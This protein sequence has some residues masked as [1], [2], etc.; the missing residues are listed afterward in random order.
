MLDRLPKLDR[1]P[2][3]DRLKV[4]ARR[5]LQN[6]VAEVVEDSAQRS[7]QAG[8][9]SHA[10][11]LAEIARLHEH[12]DLLQA[13]LDSEA[14]KTDE[15][16]R[17]QDELEFRERRD[18]W[19]AEDQLVTME[20]AEFVMKHM[21]KTP[22]FWDQYDTLRFALDEVKVPGMA[23]EF[24]VATGTTLRI[25]AESLDDRLVAGFDVFTGLPE[26]WR[27][28]FPAGQFA[29]DPPEVP[30]ATIVIGM[31]ED[32]LPGFLAEHDEQIA[33]LHVDADL[34]SSAKTVLDLVT[35]RL[36]PGAVLLFDE[37]FNYPNWQQHEYRAF[38]EFIARTGRTFTY[39]GYTGNNEQVA[40][41]LD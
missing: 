40:V 38:T 14:A 25:I 7:Q 30:G 15:I 41:R 8:E 29:Q 23:L 9:K 36:Q 2:R 10:E 34:Y 16:R 3:L 26:T 4:V 5:K 27:T 32:T 22:V 17:R 28:G 18:I 19:Y 13:R 35:D 6:A 39:L 37:F 24:G 12:L 20:S 1:L 33:F 31:F 11:L 21:A